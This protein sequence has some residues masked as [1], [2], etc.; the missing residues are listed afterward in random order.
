MILSP[1]L[2]ITEEAALYAEHARVS[3]CW[4]LGVF[5]GGGDMRS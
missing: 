3:V 2:L 4:V 1:S 5:G